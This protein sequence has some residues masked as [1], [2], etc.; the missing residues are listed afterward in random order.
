MYLIVIMR[1]VLDHDNAAINAC[2][3]NTKYLAS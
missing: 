3:Q 2:E 1:F